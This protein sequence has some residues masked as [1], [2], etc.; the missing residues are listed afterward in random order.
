MK[1][2]DVMTTDIVTVDKDRNLR[3]VL[4]L[5]DQHRITKI[6]VVEHG[7][8]VG[9][10]TDGRIADKL[11]RIRNKQVQTT[12]LH[13]SSVMEKDFIVA[14]PDEDLESLLKDVGQPGLTMIPVVK[15]HDLV[16]VV[17]KADL[18]P[19][20]DSDTPLRELMHKEIKA[21][22]PT[23]RIIHARRL[24]LDNQIGRL[25]VLDGGEVRGIIAEHE[26]AGAFAGFKMADLSVQKVNIRDMQVG[27]YM[28]RDV[29]TAPP[30]AT[31]KE[32]ARL[33]MAHHVGALPI[34]NGR[35]TIEGI[36]T[37]TDLIRTYAALKTAGPVAS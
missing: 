13:A 15:G 32:A 30:G 22:S 11:G 31:A 26:I 14:H 35:R 29:V 3:D 2:R 20:V 21:V 23:E 9:I 7:R 5:M 19:L 17:T 12:T 25:P 36:V 24:I 27:E 6:P 16:G 1:V 37:R 8:L 4:D 18:L 10:V 34:V 28:V 33:M